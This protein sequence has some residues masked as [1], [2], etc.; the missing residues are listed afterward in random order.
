[1]SVK[2]NV[3][4]EYYVAVIVILCIIVIKKYVPSDQVGAAVLA[5]I[6]LIL[7]VVSLFLVIET[8]DQTKK[9]NFQSEQAFKLTDKTLKISMYEQQIR[10]LIESSEEFYCPLK[11]YLLLDRKRGFSPE[12]D[13]I[14]GYHYFYKMSEVERHKFL[15]TK[16]IEELF[17]LYY[18]DNMDGE[19][20]EDYRIDL[21]TKV[22]DRIS[23][24]ERDIKRLKAKIREIE[25]SELIVES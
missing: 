8:L 9:A 18:N 12:L 5:T 14:E 13:K 10:D 23:E 11:D 3:R 22:I 17:N 19:Y 15:A 16:D 21:L 20:G 4:I 1:M 6:G 24:N 25:D 2:Q 7:S